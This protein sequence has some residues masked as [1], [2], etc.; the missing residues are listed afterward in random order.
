MS[1]DSPTVRP[2]IIIGAARSGTKYLRDILGSSD[3]ACKVP[4]DINYI[5]RAYNETWP[6]DAIPP[7]CAT[8]KV[9]KFIRAQIE[10]LAGAGTPG[11][12][13]L[14]EKTVGNSLRL[15]FVDA[16]YPD[17]LYIH[18]LRDGRSVTESASRQWSEPPNWGRL[19]EKLRGMPLRNASYVLWFAKNYF[20]GLGSGRGGGKVWGPRYPGIDDDLAAGASVTTISAKQWAA[21]VAMAQNHLQEVDPDRVCTVRYEELVDG[22]TEIRRLCDFCGLPDVDAVAARHMSKVDRSTAEKW[23]ES[24]S[25]EQQAEMM[26]EIE[27]LLVKL[28]YGNTLESAQ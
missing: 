13:V 12:S 22:D 9:R 11:A 26:R 27:P 20:A 19:I 8:G 1:H 23:R 18:L 24:M 17:A 5:W 14:L 3:A 15:P 4:Y 28:N 6:D 10:R 16:V 25:A 2:V 7:E 21:S